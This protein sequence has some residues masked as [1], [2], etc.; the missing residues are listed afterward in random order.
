MRFW[1][2]SIVAV[3]AVGAGRA[4]QRD[5]PC[6]FLGIPFPGTPLQHALTVGSPMS[7]PP[8]MLGALLVGAQRGRHDVVGLLSALFIVGILS[9]P[10]TW[11]ALRRPRSDPPSTVCVAA[12]IAL[13]TLLL[14]EALLAASK[15]GDARE[16]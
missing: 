11:E 14:A 16:P 10:D 2:R 7:A 15:Q 1:A 5:R 3:S 4:I 12:E 13:P 9:E 8:V 6:R